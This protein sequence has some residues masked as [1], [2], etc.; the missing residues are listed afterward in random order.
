M[1]NKL[2]NYVFIIGKLRYREKVGPPSIEIRG[3]T[4]TIIFVVKQYK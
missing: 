2:T 4:A 3:S 1:H